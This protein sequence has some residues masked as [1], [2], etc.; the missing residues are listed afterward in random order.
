MLLLHNY[1]GGLFLTR[2]L[3]QRGMATI[4]LVAFITVVRQF[5]PLLG[6]NGLL[7]VAQHLPLAL[8]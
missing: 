7:S 5:K 3:I 4:Y 1:F 6:E 2:L 8:L